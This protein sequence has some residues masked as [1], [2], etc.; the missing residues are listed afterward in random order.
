MRLRLELARWRCVNPDCARQ[1]FGDRLPAVA[2]PY[3][4]RT[5]RV[6]ELAGL[7]T[8]MA[9]GRPARRLMTGSARPRARILSCE[10]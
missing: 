5:G 9:G 2:R 10:R 8:H 6:I 1:T 7:V 4:R 3:A